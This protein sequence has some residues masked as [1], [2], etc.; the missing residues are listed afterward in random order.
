[1]INV[2]HCAGES[3][4]EMNI[5]KDSTA[6]RAPN[7]EQRRSQDI[8]IDLKLLSILDYISLV[9]YRQWAVVEQKLGVDLD[10]I[11]DSILDI[12]IQ[13]QEF[14]SLLRRK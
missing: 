10:G 8:D 9:L 7:G 2:R 11:G 6:K 4:C 13:I 14:G 5:T 12:K 3:M 1:M